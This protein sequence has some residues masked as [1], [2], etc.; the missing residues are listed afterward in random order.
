MV[1]I[2]NVS[3]YHIIVHNLPRSHHLVKKL[4]RIIGDIT[5]DFIEASLLDNF[6]KY[7]YADKMKEGK[8]YNIDNSFFIKIVLPSFSIFH[9]MNSI[10]YKLARIDFRKACQKGD[11]DSFDISYIKQNLN[12]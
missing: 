10:E 2:K 11:L 12:L 9:I 3:C 7:V 4:Y 5:K 8:K 6:G 1:F